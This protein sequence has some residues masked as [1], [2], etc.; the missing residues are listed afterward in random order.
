MR[1]ILAAATARPRVST[2]TFDQ[3]LRHY[4]RVA[5]AEEP[6]AEEK[7]AAEKATADKAA[8]D[9]AAADKA[10]ADKV[11]EDALG[12]AGKRAL[13][14]E[15]ARAQAAE[16]RA[17]AAE[18]KAKEYEDRDKT[19]LQKAQDEAAT[20]KTE[21]AKATAALLRRQVADDKKLPVDLADTLQGST[22]EELEAHADVLLKH[23]KPQET[24]PPNFNGGAGSPPAAGSLDA[25]IQA[26]TAK[27]DWAAV[28]TLNAQKLSELALNKKE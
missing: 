27:G 28:Q 25:Q 6:T 7:A 19:D 17:K 8:A 23:I 3:F 21:A 12:D 10:T 9:K 13:V 24:P 11:A 18:A 26:A 15:R 16:D 5:G 1:S 4:P 2:L 14:A 22:K 20:A